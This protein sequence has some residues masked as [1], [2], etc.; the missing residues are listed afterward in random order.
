MGVNC[1]ITVNTH[2]RPVKLTNHHVVVMP[3]GHFDSFRY[4]LA[5]SLFIGVPRFLLPF[6]N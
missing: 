4:H 5:R 6:G 1:H 2:D 3:L